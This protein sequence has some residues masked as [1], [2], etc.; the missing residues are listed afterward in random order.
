MGIIGNILGQNK[1]KKENPIDSLIKQQ[2]DKVNNDVEKYINNDDYLNKW[3][4]EWLKD[5]MEAEENF[6]EAMGSTEVTSQVG[7]EQ[8]ENNIEETVIEE[9]VKPLDNKENIIK[10]ESEKVKEIDNELN[11]VN[12]EINN[13][14]NK[15]NEVHN[16]VVEQYTDI[17]IPLGLS[18]EDL[19]VGA[20]PE[21]V[22]QD[23]EFGA[24]IKNVLNKSAERKAIDFNENVKNWIKRV[25]ELGG[26]PMFVTHYGGQPFENHVV[27]GR[28]WGAKGNSVWFKN[29]PE[30]IYQGLEN[31]SIKAKEILNMDLSKSALP[32]LI[33]PT[34]SA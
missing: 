15:A 3:Y 7:N 28:A 33:S 11:K 32:Q 8:P 31:H 25:Y 19:V 16:E 17:F 30:D 4:N 18:Q 34:S 23:S 10:I 12:K 26:Y 22:E 21:L 14:L 2:I 9:E 27:M 1:K 24:E 20:I 13:K 5:T 29:V 6:M